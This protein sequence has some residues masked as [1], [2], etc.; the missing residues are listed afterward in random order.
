MEATK[1]ITVVASVYNEEPNIEAFCGCIV[2]EASGA[3]LMFDVLFVDDGSTDG[4]AEKIRRLSEADPRVG[5]IKLSR[6]FGHEAAMLAGIDNAEGDAVICMD[7]DLQHPPEMIPAMA[8]KFL[9]GFDV[10]NMTRNKNSRHTPLG[11][12]FMS[13]LFY[14]FLNFVTKVRLE[15]NAS[16]FFLISRKA[17]DALRNGYRER[18]RFLRG[19]IQIMGFKKT[20]LAYDC[21]KRLAGKSKYTFRSLLRLSVNALTSFS[22]VPLRMGIFLGCITGAASIAAAVYSLAMRLTTETPPGYTTIVTLICLLFSI[23]F[24]VLGIIGEYIGH[25]LHEV[26][27]RPIYIVDEIVR[28]KRT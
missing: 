2:K 24:F 27:G 28:F 7:S 11:K 18:A 9:E 5:M 13:A 12:R 8:K 22:N 21:G 15:E 23:N 6:N 3:G 26:K 1:H 16:D 14:K 20:S 19:F 10:V 17:A 25:V 4:G